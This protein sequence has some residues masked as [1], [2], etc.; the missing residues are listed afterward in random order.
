MS[1]TEEAGVKDAANANGEGSAADVFALL[2]AGLAD[3]LGTAAAATLL[4]RAAQCALPRA[5][6]L[7][8]LR[9]ARQS[10]EYRY[11]LPSSWTSVSGPRGAL[12]ALARELWPLLVDLTGSVVIQRL[13]QH[14]ELRALGAAPRSESEP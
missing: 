11:T 6:E 14:P 12:Q 8:A 4:R 9:I 13:A 5:P 1:G 10:L 3:I 7:A 2:W